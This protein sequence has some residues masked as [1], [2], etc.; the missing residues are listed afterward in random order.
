MDHEFRDSVNKICRPSFFSEDARVIAQI[1]QPRCKQIVQ[2]FRIRRPAQL[3]NLDQDYSGMLFRPANDLQS[4]KN[5]STTE[6]KVEVVGAESFLVEPKRERR[7]EDDL[8]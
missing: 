5:T 4:G 1:P 3:I 6:G 8:R 7:S 2:K